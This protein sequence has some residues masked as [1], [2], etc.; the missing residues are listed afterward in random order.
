VAFIAGAGVAK[1]MLADLH[2]KVK[3]TNPDS[4]LKGMQTPVISAGRQRA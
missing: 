4:L 1:T 2:Y 3:E